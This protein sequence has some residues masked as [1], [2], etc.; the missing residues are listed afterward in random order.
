[1]LD[2]S[3]RQIEAPRLYRKLGFV[4][5]PAYQALPPRLGDWLVFM[6]MDLLAENTV[7]RSS[8]GL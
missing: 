4:E 5:C 3:V 2:T 8:G 6:R 1:V 7:Q